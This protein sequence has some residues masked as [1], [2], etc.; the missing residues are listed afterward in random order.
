MYY[1]FIWV[2]V[3]TT[4]CCSSKGRLSKVLT[5]STFFRLASKW[6]GFFLGLTQ[7]FEKRIHRNAY[8]TTMIGSNSFKIFETDFKIEIVIIY[9][10]YFAHKNS[11][12]GQR[13][14]DHRKN[15]F[16]VKLKKNTYN[17]KSKNI[18]KS[19]ADNHVGTFSR[20]NFSYSFAKPPR[21]LMEVIY[22][23]RNP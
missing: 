2:I 6:I 14:S 12:P 17:T 20:G 9:I 13:F 19:V 15:M 21:F 5:H 22:G 7:S 8:T 16:L 10:I 3:S 1:R 18:R 23:Q 4:G 11:F